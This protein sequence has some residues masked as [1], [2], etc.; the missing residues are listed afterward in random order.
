ITPN[1][2]IISKVRRT[3]YNSLEYYW[4]DLE[5][6]ELTTMLLDLQFKSSKQNTVLTD[7]LVK[8]T[9]IETPLF[10]SN[11]LRKI[12]SYSQNQTNYEIEIDNYLNEMI[13]SSL[14]GDTNIYNW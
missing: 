11:F 4:H 14:S 1:E 12:F 6:T 7:N 13:T 3:I 10:T 8:D 2:K 9:D 5:Y